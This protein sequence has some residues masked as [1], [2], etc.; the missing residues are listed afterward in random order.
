MCKMCPIMT[1]RNFEKY[2]PQFFTILSILVISVLMFKMPFANELKNEMLK[3]DF[4]SLIVTVETTLFGFLLAILAIVLQ[5]NNKTV[6]LIKKY[7]RYNELLSYSK[8][9]VKSCFWVVILTSII[10]LF[11]KMFDGSVFSIIIFIFW[12]ASLIYNFL[13]TYRF[14]HIFYEISKSN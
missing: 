8:Q 3:P 6:E 1:K 11:H 10:I 12:L 13:C 2:Y 9:S 4:L 14:V 5:L 7:N